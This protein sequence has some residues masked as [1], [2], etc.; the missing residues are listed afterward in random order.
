[1]TGNGG[2]PLRR[3]A[4][5]L[6]GATVLL[7]A[8][9]AY[10]YNP[11]LAVDDAFISFR[12]AVNLAHGF[13]LVYNPGERV[14]GYSNFLWTVLM[15]AGA[16]VGMDLSLLAMVISLLSA[17]VTLALLWDW[18]RR[19][20]ARREEAV[21]MALPALVFAA[22]G[23]QAR[24]VVSGME[25]LFFGCLLMAAL[26]ALIVKRRPLGAGLLFGLA[27]MT[28]PEGLMYASLA[29]GMTLLAGSDEDW[30]AAAN[31]G[32]GFWGEPRA[33]RRNLRNAL[34]LAGGALLLFVPY[35]AWRYHYYGYPFPNT[36]YAKAG[37]FSVSR[38]GRGLK[39]LLEV[40]GMWSAFPLWLL[41][42]AGMV[43]LRRRLTLQVSAL[44][45][46][47]TIAYFVF[48]G[49]DFLGFFGPRFLMPIFPLL[50][51]LVAEGLR[52]AAELCRRLI[53]RRRAAAADASR[54]SRTIAGAALV[55]VALLAGNALWCSWPADF[56]RLPLLARQMEALKYLGKWLHD[57][58]PSTAVLAT[59]GAGIVPFYSERYTIDMYGL[60][61]E[62]IGHMKPLAVGF[63][64]VAH[65]KFDPRY[66]LDR[67]PDLLLSYME[68]NG[69]A[70]AAGLARANQ[71]VWACYRPLVLMRDVEDRSTWV[72]PSH[73]Y[74]PALW[75]AGYKIVVFELRR[76]L[77]AAGC[78]AFE[79]AERRAAG[80][81]VAPR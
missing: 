52:N 60:A 29:A 40:S 62:H 11:F 15:A 48:V 81:A 12:Y 67:K 54:R 4:L 31:R 16:R 3:A 24:Y 21:F 9:I 38:L 43:T 64:Q 57:S 22:T 65:E 72:L 77:D 32:A 14:E 41:A 6:V 66:V 44:W 55:S 34:L 18:S 79:A 42:M 8:R 58:T 25:T 68:R 37:G 75:D 49:G 46:L 28:R 51:L 80:A 45:V 36:Y 23:S 47:V 73:Q 50:L 76:G 20:Y 17:L 33:R 56:D 13:G 53:D 78:A 59:G 19:L 69:L 74:T 5:T 1:M 71:R 70:R 10:I 30:T 39:V 7:L 35:F 61:D 26:Y 63:K 27:T 2:L